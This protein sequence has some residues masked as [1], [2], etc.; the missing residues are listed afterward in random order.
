MKNEGLLHE[1]VPA[2]APGFLREEE[3]GM[4]D[5]QDT[6]RSFV[7]VTRSWP[8]GPG[9]HGLWLDMTTRG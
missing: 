5:A 1:L 9:G 3:D 7:N 8:S 6:A 2:D 4:T